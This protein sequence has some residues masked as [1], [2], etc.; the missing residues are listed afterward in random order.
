VG[1]PDDDGDEPLGLDFVLSPE[2]FVSVPT[3][4]LV[5]PVPPED[6]DVEAAGFSRL[7]VR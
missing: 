7:S 6:S 4:F 2:V 5:S 1:E 3:A